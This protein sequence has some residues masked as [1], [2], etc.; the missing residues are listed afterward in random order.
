MKKLLVTLALLSSVTAIAG[1]PGDAGPN[2]MICQGEYALCAASSTKPTG[3]TITVNGTDFKEGVAVCPV[4]SGKS[5][6]DGN[7]MN[8]SCK[9]PKGKVWSLFSAETSY[10]QAPTW[11][12]TTA[13]IR[14]FTS[15]AAPGGGM[16]NMWSF[17]CVKRKEKVN[18]AKLADCFGP[19]NESPWDA[20]AVPAG[21]TIGTASPVGANDPVGGPFNKTFP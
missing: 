8:N 20:T 17:P 11:A 21:S 16:S 15:T 6:A 14:T 10:P 1:K 9:S 3:K 18:G 4:L 7:L 13:V 2:L 19:M 12:V 5:I